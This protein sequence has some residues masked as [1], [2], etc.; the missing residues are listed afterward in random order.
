MNKTNPRVRFLLIAGYITML[1]ELLCFVKAGT[2]YLFM[3][4][5]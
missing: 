4:P 5:G 3:F 2:V 1:Y